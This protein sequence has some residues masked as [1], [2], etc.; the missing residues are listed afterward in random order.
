MLSDQI[1]HFVLEQASGQPAP[2]RAALYRS[3]ADSGVTPV[4]KKKLIEMAEQ[5]EA[6]ES[7]SRQI[8]FEFQL[9]S[10]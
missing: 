5:L 2:K 8:T 4:L 10:L 9:N 7:K 1:T 3:L 6:V